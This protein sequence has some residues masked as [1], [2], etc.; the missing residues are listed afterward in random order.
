[1]LLKTV[2]IVGEYSSSVMNELKIKLSPKFHCIHIPN[3]QSF[4]K[5]CEADYVI[6]RGPKMYAS[7]LEPLAGKLKL[8]Q[9]WGS[10]YDG[11]D[12]KK[13]GELGISVA[14]TNGVNSN[15]VSELAIALMLSLYRHIIPLN[16]SVAS[17]IWERQVYIDKTYE[18]NGK[19]VGLIGCGNIGRLVAKKVQSLGANVIYYDS[20]RMTPEREKDLN[21][22]YAEA[23]ELLKQSDII[24]LHLPS[25]PATKGMINKDYLSQMK[26]S[27]ILI[28]TARGSIINENDLYE[29]LK[30]NWI[31]GA[32]LDTLE[33]EP[34]SPDNPLL[35]LDNIVI[36][37]HVGGNTVDM[38]SIM[39]SHVVDNIIR[40]DNN[41]PI[42]IPIGDL[43]NGEYLIEQKNENMDISF[44]F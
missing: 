10:G 20:Y 9:R 27:A 31:L 40:V 15:A 4:D 44:C 7:I 29:A 8:I 26:P 36:T 22:K 39:V 21:I 37:P 16:N 18:I 17:G 38:N 23:E 43:V 33:Q 34:P 3:N 11:V 14:I 19:T 42:P 13:A 41:E 30:N 1:M 6:L 32:G 24:S 28:N 5:L 2:A 25:T 35:T 12:V